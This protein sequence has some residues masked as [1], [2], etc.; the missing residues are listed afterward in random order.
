MALPMAAM[1]M[2]ACIDRRALSIAAAIL[3]LAMTFLAMTISW[4]SLGGKVMES[5]T[6]RRAAGNSNTVAVWQWR[7]P[8]QFS[9]NLTLFS[10]G[11]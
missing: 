3:A 8:Q 6:T 7:S 5:H 11:T 2:A 1:I 9:A 10:F 4:T